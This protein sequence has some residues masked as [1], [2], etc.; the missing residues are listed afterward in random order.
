V[1]LVIL[2]YLWCVKTYWLMM[3]QKIGMDYEEFI[4]LLIK[5]NLTNSLNISWLHDLQRM[6]DSFSWFICQSIFYLYL[7]YLTPE[8]ITIAISQRR[9]KLMVHVRS[10]N[11]ATSHSQIQS[12]RTQSVL[13]WVA[14]YRMLAKTSAWK[15]IAFASNLNLYQ[16]YDL[17]SIS[18]YDR[19]LIK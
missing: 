4:F 7:F 17:F 6:I 11:S 1:W 13:A 19:N 12:A 10:L 3:H 16:F 2:F 5:C 8:F 15:V 18:V 14:L 9:L